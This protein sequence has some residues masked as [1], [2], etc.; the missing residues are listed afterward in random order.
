VNF[1][2]DQIDQGKYDEA[3]PLYERSLKIYETV[4]GENHPEVATT[5]NNLA[6]L[7]MNQGKYDEAKPLYERA[8]KIF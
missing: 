8:L 1:G 2:P 4:L 7:L 6:N 5:L 3:K